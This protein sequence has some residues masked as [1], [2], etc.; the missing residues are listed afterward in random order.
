[1]HTDL[2]FIIF[3]LFDQCKTG[4]LLPTKYILVNTYIYALFYS[5]LPSTYYVLNVQRCDD[6]CIQ[7]YLNQH[8]CR[9]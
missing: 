6:D 3:I 8:A 2:C 1:M 9:S 4:N 7:Q 5:I